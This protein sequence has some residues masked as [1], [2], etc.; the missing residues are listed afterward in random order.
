M[1]AIVAPV[2]N[3]ADPPL[4]SAIFGNHVVLQRDRPIDVYGRARPGESVTVTLSGT[5]QQVSTD[6]AGH[7]RVALPALPAGG[8]YTLSARTQDRAQT[9]D[10]VLIGDV[11]LCSGQSNMEWVVRNTLNAWN[12]AQHSAN[13]RIRQVTIPR[14]AAA[15][16]R[17]DF[18]HALEWKIAGPATTGDFSAVCYYTVRELQKTV[19]VPMGM[20]VSSWGGTRIET[21][22]SR[23]KL[24]ELGGNDANLDLLAEYATDKP[25]AMR[26]WG[27][28]FEKWWLSQAPTKGTKP[29]VAAKADASAWLPAP[30]VEKNWE[31]WGVPALTEYDG[32]MWFRARVTLTKAQAAQAATLSLGTVDDVDIAWVNGRAMGSGF[33]EGEHAYPVPAKLLKAGDNFIVLNVFDMWGTGGLEGPASGRQLRFADGTSAALEGWEYQL[34]PAKLWAPRAPWEAIAGLNILYNGMIAPLGPFGLR[35]VQWYQGEANA[36]LDDALRYQQQL[37]GLF[38]DWRRQFGAPLPFLVVQLANFGQL[39]HGPV[40]SGWAQLRDAQRRAVTADGNAGLA[41]TIDIGNRDDIHPQNKQDVGKRMAR[42]ARKIVYGGKESGWGARPESARRV[43]GGVL[44]TFGD[45]EGEL[46]VVGSK[47]PSAFELCGAMAESCRFVRAKLRDGA[48]VLLED[49]ASDA[50]RVRFCWADSPLCNLYD[51]AGLPAGP[52]QLDVN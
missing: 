40:D 23:E 52:F 8:P 49:A 43:D 48:S 19:N 28:S 51:S 17:E 1:A 21:W 37:Q 47:E 9:V 25:A 36:G 34:P 35:G 4:M 46:R 24:R 10:D 22:L 30:S 14:F 6:A 44:V 45:A 33:G 15:T 5:T 50:T 18:E 38:A 39:T 7:W 27:E 41:V 16:P 20:V 31:E 32:M 3:A 29:W 11:W 12:E 2:A 42:A 26:H 13:D